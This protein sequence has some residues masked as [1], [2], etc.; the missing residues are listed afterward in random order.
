MLFHLHVVCCEL[1][2]LFTPMPQKKSFVE[3]LSANVT[4]LDIKLYE[5][6]KTKWGPKG[7]VP[8]W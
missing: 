2:C 4:V 1:N 3:A 8:V 5:V 6:I 7:G